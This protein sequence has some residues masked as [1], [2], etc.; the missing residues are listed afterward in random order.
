MQTGASALLSAAGVAALYAL[1][2]AFD[3]RGASSAKPVNAEVPEAASEQRDDFVQPLE[4]APEVVEAVEEPAASQASRKTRA[5]P[6]KKASRQ[7][8]EATEELKVEIAPSEESE[9]LEVSQVATPEE[10]EVVVPLHSDEATHPHIEPLFEA[11]PFVRMP[12][13]AFG[14]KAG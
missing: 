1:V 11:E 8:A 5:K 12:R 6:R 9:E 14:R 10:T 13:P 7:R 3:A 2:H 4:L